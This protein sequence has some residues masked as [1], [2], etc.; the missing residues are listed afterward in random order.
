MCV[1]FEI[2]LLY[3][4]DWPKRKSKTTVRHFYLFLSTLWCNTNEVTHSLSRY[5]VRTLYRFSFGLLPV[6]V[7][8]LV[9]SRLFLFV[10]ND[11]QNTILVAVS[12][13][14]STLPHSMKNTHSFG[15]AKTNR[16][17]RQKRTNEL[18]LFRVL[19]IIWYQLPREGCFPHHHCH[20]RHH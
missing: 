9:S 11:C 1:V 10:D 7:H 4:W 16:S 8:L 6:V 18:L 17:T 2:L 15:K 5:Y 20:H 3:L 19:I 12:S 13:V 14:G